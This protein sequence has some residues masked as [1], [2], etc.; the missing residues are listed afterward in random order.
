MESVYLQKENKN[1]Y[2]HFKLLIFVFYNFFSLFFNFF[3]FLLE[4]KEKKPKFNSN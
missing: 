4:I 1:N 2:I 3:F